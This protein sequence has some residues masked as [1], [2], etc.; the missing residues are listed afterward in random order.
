MADLPDVAAAIL[1]AS[2]CRGSARPGP[3]EHRGTYRGFRGFPDGLERERAGA[4]LGTGQPSPEPVRSGFRATERFLA[5]PFLCAGRHGFRVRLTERSAPDALSAARRRQGL[6]RLDASRSPTASPFGGRRFDLPGTSG[7]FPGCRGRRRAGRDAFIAPCDRTCRRTLTHDLGRK[8]ACAKPAAEP[9]RVALS[10]L[11]WMKR[12]HR[13]SE[14][15]GCR[16]ELRLDRR[17]Q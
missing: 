7:G 9:G 15:R 5:S 12:R 3:G 13:R 8:A 10:Q 6:E 17:H 2:L 4:R 1:A 14:M 16:R 11:L